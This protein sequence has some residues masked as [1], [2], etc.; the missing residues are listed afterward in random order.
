MANQPL[1]SICLTTFNRSEFLPK[2]LQS[3][4]NQDFSD[5][6]LIIS[7]D[8]STDETQATCQEFMAKDSRIRYIRN[9]ENL[10]MP[11]NLNSAIH[12]A[13]GDY[14]ANLHD[15]DIYRSDLI[16]KWKRALDDVPTAG[17]VFNAYESVGKYGQ[18]CIFRM[19][20]PFRVPKY[21]VAQHFFRTMT[22]CVWGTVMAR[23]SAYEKIGSFNSRFGFIS[24]VDMW[25]RLSRDYDVVYIDEPL[26]TLMPRESNHPYAS[27]HW[28]L[29]F[30][31]LA[32]YFYHLHYYQKALPSE[33][34][35]LIKNYGHRRRVLMLK[36]ALSCVKN[37]QWT[38]LLEGLSTW[39]DSEDVLLRFFGN[40]FCF[41][42]RKPIW[43]QSHYW[44]MT[45]ILPG[46]EELS[47]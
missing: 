45:K 30:Y 43:Y 33:T 8:C 39:Q 31:V 11:G 23:R 44:E 32:I 12:H 38:L 21:A 40:I 36:Q 47:L 10:K 37:R 15:G 25:L 20:F 17:F 14:V 46:A 16:S 26:I 22:S 7:D 34:G 29:T 3:L 18:S 24:D 41:S 35:S 6:E 19:P 13:S 2:T 4:L 28:Q 1:V 5:F 9:A 27:F 42:K